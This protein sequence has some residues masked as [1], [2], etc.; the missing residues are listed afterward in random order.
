MNT[1]Q[2]TG[3]LTKDPELRQLPGTDQE[4]A[5]LRLAVDGAGRHN[6]VGYFDVISYGNSGAAAA[7]TLTRGWLVAVDGRLEFREWTKDDEKRSAVAIVGRVEFLA[8]PRGAEEAPAK[9]DDDI[10]F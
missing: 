2:V 10:P 9:G 1:V 8:A 4:V 3:R 5:E 6:D 7:R